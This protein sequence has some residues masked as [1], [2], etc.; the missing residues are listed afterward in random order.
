MLARR[1]RVGVVGVGKTREIGR[2]AANTL[3]E[4]IEVG[5]AGVVLT[6]IEAIGKRRG[7]CNGV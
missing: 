6:D 3:G 2:A 4:G 1:L 7:L 5:S